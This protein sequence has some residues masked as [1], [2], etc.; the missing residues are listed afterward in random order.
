MEH[1]DYRIRLGKLSDMAGVEALYS[2]VHDA[3][4]AGPNYSGWKRGWYADETDLPWLLPSPSLNSCTANLLYAGMC[5]FEGVST[6]SEGRG[7]SKPFE[8]IGAPW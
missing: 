6:I 2:A 4:E 1:G 8:L 3:V 5:V 7:T